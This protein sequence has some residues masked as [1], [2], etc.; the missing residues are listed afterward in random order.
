MGVAD[1]CPYCGVD[2]RKVGVRLKRAASSADPGYG[3]TGT[4]IGI[5]LLFFAAALM[6]G[7]VQASNQAMEVISVDPGVLFRIGSQFNPA[8]DAG[9]WWRVITPIFLHM[10]L[11]HV[12]FNNYALWWGG[13]VVEDDIGGRF[14]LLTYLVSGILGF[15]A[16]Y[17]ASIGGAGASGAV[18]GMIGFVLVR[19]YLMD[20]HLR[21]PDGRQAL[22]YT[23]LMGV[24]GFVI[25]VNNV[26][27][28]VGWLA[29]GGMA[30]LLSKVKLGRTGAVVMMVSTWVV[31][32]VT[33]L[34]AVL[35]VM[36]LFDGSP[37]DFQAARS[38]Y[39][40]KVEPVLRSAPNLRGRDIDAAIVCVRDLKPLEAESNSATKDVA[41]ALS[42][43]QRAYD[44]GDSGGI[45]RG[46]TS[47]QQGFERWVDWY[48]EAYPRY[49]G[50]GP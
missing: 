27:H 48:Q 13:R 3:V 39:A 36:S 37:G 35:M 17:F 16:S 45:S 5:N 49:P 21:H 6:V 14:M 7:G 23:V 31:T 34:A 28:A 8:I 40:S 26:A 46:L 9:Q 29:G 44:D 38:C 1:V 30:T 19:R 2:N 18:S 22:M 15:V 24:M 25:N 43:L 50:S 33:L 4:I 11:L 41:A 42:V 32:G 12:V 10:G 47:L 20:G